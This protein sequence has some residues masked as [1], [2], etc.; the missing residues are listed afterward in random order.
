MQKRDSSVKILFNRMFLSSRKLKDEV[1]VAFGLIFVTLLVLV[2]YLFPG[3]MSIFEVK[4]SLPLIIG[5]GAVIVI[6]G[7]MIIIQIIEPVIKIS[8]QAKMIAKGDLTRDIELTREDEL[9]ELGAALNEMTSKIRTNVE[10]LKALSK[11]TDALKEEINNRIAMLSNLME[12]SN[13]IAQNAPLNDVVDIALKRCFAT[14]DMTFGGAVLK[15]RVTNEFKVAYIS[16][17]KGDV[18]ISKGIK[19]IK[20]PLGQGVL[21]KAILQQHV[22]IIDEKTPLT[23]EIE[24]FKGQFLLKNAVIAPISSKG[25]AYGLLIAGNDESKF[26][27][28]GTDKELLQLVAKHVAIAV[29]NDL[30]TKEIERFEITD[31]LTALFNN[32]FARN[33]LNLDIQQAKNFQRTC[34]F[35]LFHV[36]RFEELSKDFGHI[37]SEDALI[38][39]AAVL[40][41]SISEDES[42]ARFADHEFALILPEK[43]KKD[44]IGLVN[45][46]VKK[47]EQTFIKESDP[48]KRLT[49]TAAVVENPIDGVTADELILKSGVILTEHL[50]KGGNQVGY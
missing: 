49:V 32:A 15:D 12:I 22:V 43:S 30:L 9:G 23:R 1:L 21:G 10:E 29:L 33:K 25:N 35:A 2:G 41:N 13:A 7:F 31:G 40:K 16:G 44:S 6:I 11:N 45:E 27:C 14:R 50:E 26:V 5:I 3:M 47:I 38:K 20:I 18:L 8:R 19:D 28:S 48:R 36:D 46:I 37:E 42:A 17:P 24:D 4:G 34:S 39:I